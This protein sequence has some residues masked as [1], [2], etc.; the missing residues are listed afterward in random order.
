M[1]EI[2]L[3][4]RTRDKLSTGGLV[5]TYVGTVLLVYLLFFQLI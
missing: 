5:I 3:T 2:R 1:K 4:E